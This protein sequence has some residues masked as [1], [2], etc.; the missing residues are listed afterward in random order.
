[1]ASQFLPQLTP[2]FDTVR[3]GGSGIRTQA[4][5]ATATQQFTFGPFLE[6]AAV[7]T[8]AP[9]DST[10]PMD[11]LYVSGYS[12]RLTQPLLRGADPAVSAEPLRDARRAVDTQGRSLEVLRRRTVLLIYQLYL[13]LARQQEAVRLAADQ[14]ERARRLAQ[15]SQARFLAGSVSRLDVLRAEQQLAS[16]EVDRNNAENLAD[17][18]RDQLRRAA[19][20]AAEFEFTI[21]PPEEIPD[22]EPDLDT[23]LSGL[24]SRRPEA[25]EAQEL[26]HDSQ[27]NVRIARSLELPSLDAVISYE[28]VGSG[29]NVGDALPPRNGVFLFGF[30]TQYGLNYTALYAQRREAEIALGTRVRNSQVLV[31]DLAREVRRAYRRLEAQR[32]NEVIA[33]ENLKVAELQAK[34]ARLRFEKG[35]SDNFNVVDADNLWNSARLL[36][37]DSR[38]NIL[39]AQLDC[40]YASGSIDIARFLQQQ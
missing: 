21:R 34:V 14:M 23:A 16:A 24:G 22:A 31:D 8:H 28:A 38:I 6:G 13:G 1:M 3:A 26:V 37:L 17:D 2:F 18:L 9:T 25:V 20:L 30:R 33:S 15:F 12:L 27:L 7:V 5:G 32:Q 40:L 19:G 4:F 39:L 10:D 35:L 29:R 36:E 11:P